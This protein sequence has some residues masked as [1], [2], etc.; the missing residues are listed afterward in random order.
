MK[1]YLLIFSIIIFAFFFEFLF[2][3][4]FIIFGMRPPLV[5]FAI[6]SSY[7]FLTISERIV[8]GFFGGMLLE[9]VLASASGTQS[10]LFVFLAF[11]ADAAKNIFFSPRSPGAQAA[12]T[13]ALLFLFLTFLSSVDALFLWIQGFGKPF[14]FSLFYSSFAGSFFWSAACFMG[15]FVSRYFFNRIT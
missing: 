8:F 3:R 12:S 5:A 6:F 1:K 10:A 4:F 11:A 9:T 2:G 15:V 13:G 7:W 14:A